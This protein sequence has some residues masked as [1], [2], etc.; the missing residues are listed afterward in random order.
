MGYKLRIALRYLLSVKSH[1]AVN[2]ITLVS[3]IG[4][5]VAVAAIVCVLSVFNGFNRLVAD[6]ADIYAPELL[7][8]PTE[9]KTIAA[10]DSLTA[11]LSSIPGVSA[12]SPI[13]EERALA[14]TTANLQTPVRIV[15]VD[16]TLSVTSRLPEAV[17][18]GIYGLYTPE[19]RPLATLSAGTAI[20]LEARPGP[21][22]SLTLIVPRRKGRVNPANPASSFRTD[23]FAIAGVFQTEEQEYDN[24]MVIIPIDRAREL[25]QYGHDVSSRLNVALAPDA[26]TGHVADAIARA[27]GTDYSIKNRQQQQAT[28]YRMIAIEKW[29]TFALMGFILLV[30]SFNIVSTMSMLIIDKHSTISVLRS[31]GV[32]CKDVVGIFGRTSWLICVAGSLTGI[33]LGTALCLLQQHF[34]FIK[35]NGDSAMLIT[36]TYPVHVEAVDLLAVAAA[37]TVVAMI[38]TAIIRPFT[39]RYLRQ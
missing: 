2:V 24:D 20:A 16:N 17:I 38:M 4:V 21:E 15:G 33:V 26:D 37:T 6:R 1:M 8:E 35:L 22:S 27:A 32:P 18:D 13:I 10:T 31:L 12:V 28:S 30:A 5:A 39:Q 11:I 3:M 36:D 9:G 25:L 34:G 7:V 14:M 29:I 19:H 23:T